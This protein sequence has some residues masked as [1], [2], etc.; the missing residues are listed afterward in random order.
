[1]QVLKQSDPD[2]KQQLT[3]LKEKLG[4][5]LT[6]GDSNI[7]VPTIVGDIISDVMTSGDDAIIRLEERLDGASLTADTIRVERERIE[8]AGKEVDGEFLRI[9]RQAAEN[10]REY[11][12]YLMPDTP[13]PMMRGSRELS[14]RYTPVE[15]VGVY[16][17]GGRA[18]YP[19]SVLMTVIPAQVA[20]V[21]EIAMASP[22]SSDGDIDPMVLAMAEELGVTEVYRL[23]G[24]V[25]IAALATG[26]PNVKPV[27]KIVGPGN[28]FVA[29]AKRQLFGRVGID[30]MAGPSEVLIV[31]DDAG[32]PEWIAADMIAQAEHDP[33]SSILVTTSDQIADQVLRCLGDQSSQLERNE[34]ILAALDSYSA[35]VVVNDMD[36][37]C[38]IASDFA[39]EHL[40]I[41]TEDDDAAFA[42]I[43]N[44]GAAFL[45][46]HTPTALGDYYA[47]PSHVLPTG[48]G[49]KFSSPLSVMDFLKTTS[50]IRYDAESIAA[51]GPDV[52]SFATREGLTGHARAADI[53]LD[54]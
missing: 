7:D 22:P 54:N 53:R 5:S 23:G 43:N 48:G 33:G 36:K 9:I 12:Q 49:A 11:Q 47:G 4:G 8:G 31:A 1:M 15:R 28:A 13:S 10:V 14:V 35:I 38:A 16:V 44:A 52:S 21:G 40:Q 3:G 42:K 45:G 29:E 32:V 51:D 6:S 30:S 34:A 24:A 17:P 26:T 2:F 19:S 41:M 46:P 39:P 27:Q 25:A 18:L 20:G 50:V 37:A